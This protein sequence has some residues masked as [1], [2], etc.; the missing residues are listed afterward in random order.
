MR[1]YLLA[2]AAAAAVA[3]PAVARD[4]SPYVGIEGG[5][6]F[7]RSQSGDAFV[8]FTTTQ[9]PA[10]PA[11]PAGPADANFEN[12]FGVDYRRGIDVDVIA[13]YD[14]GMFRLEGELGWKRA[15]LREFEVDNAFINSLNIAL[16]RPSAAPDPGAPGRAALTADDVPLSGRMNII[17]AMA[18]AL[19]DI[20]ADDGLS[21]YGGPGFGRAW[22]RFQGERDSAWAWQLIAGV[23][24]A[25]SPNMDV[26]LKYRYFRTGRLGFSDDEGFALQ[27]NPDRFVINQTNVDRTTNAVVLTDFD[28]RFRSHS[29]LASLIFNFGAPAA[30]LPPPPPPPPPPPV[31]PQTRTCPDGTVVLATDACPLPPPPPPPPMPLPERG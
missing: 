15:R 9:S 26:G 3:T 18:N 6:L 2:A 24:Y 8:D 20:G 14:F 30:V 19:I 21:F 31:A 27:G 7:P 22:A 10:T 17:S 29:L 13:G 16:N 23:R 28:T 25:L 11:A 5:I 12:A 4:G 1:R